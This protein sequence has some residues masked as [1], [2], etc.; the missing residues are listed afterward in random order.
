MGDLIKL[1]A[2]EQSAGEA[3][4]A[5]DKA[6][7]LEL[8]KELYFA[9]SKN[10]VAYHNAGLL[11]AEI[12]SPENAIAWLEPHADDLNH[13][14]VYNNLANLLYR[15]GQ[16]EKAIEYYKKAILVD[17]D[18]NNWPYQNIA[19]CY[20][21]LSLHL[22]ASICSM[23][24]V[25]VA[26]HKSSVT[27]LIFSRLYD[28]EWSALDVKKETRYL[29]G[30]EFDVASFLRPFRYNRDKLKNIGFVSGDFRRHSLQY[31]LKPLL[32]ELAK[33]DDINVYLF[34]SCP[35]HEHDEITSWYRSNCKQFINIYGKNA[36]PTARLINSIGIDALVDLS[37]H[38][39]NN[40]LDV[41][42]LKPAPLQFTWMGYP[43]TT[44]LE[45]MDY[46]IS[47]K[48][49]LPDTS[50]VVYTEKPFRLSASVPFDFDELLLPSVTTAPRHQN[51]Y[52]TFGV[53]QNA[54]KINHDFLL[55]LAIDCRRHGAKV[56]FKGEGIQSLEVQKR[57]MDSMAG[58]DC[59][60]EAS[61][62]SAQYYLDHARIDAL[63]DTFPY[64][65]GTTSLIACALGVPIITPKAGEG[66]Y[67]RCGY[68]IMKH[69][70]GVIYNGENLD[71]VLNTPLLPPHETA[72]AKHEQIAKEF[73]E[74][75]RNAYANK[76][77]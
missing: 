43:F 26:S 38:T 65:G 6:K 4:R 68:A 1:R 27:S 67:Q 76:W 60:F 51:G 70:G 37:G 5:G 17:E 44:G 59:T 35:P 20:Q 66:I 22:M 62:D 40:R 13:F 12:D 52:I 30:R 33:F 73:V 74:G 3:L 50:R 21:K 54:S 61:T 28:Q 72:Y 31:F 71:A 36:M 10:Y 75:L 69:F 16:Y 8:F 11:L 15:T 41:F 2:L 23:A 47:D 25:A 9:D 57:I 29:V 42:A 19:G 64:N 53:F 49:L 56:L 14:G 48:Y 32:T 55:S 39:A 45:A 7:A 46:I 24:A 58:I 18:N 63:Y 34:S 77:G